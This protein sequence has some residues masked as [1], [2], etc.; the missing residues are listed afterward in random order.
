M[1]ADVGLC[2]CI[3]ARRF[4]VVVWCSM[5]WYGGVAVTN[6]LF[7]RRLVPRVVCFLQ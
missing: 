1:R 2:I 3:A 7:R 4:G 6:L 5:A